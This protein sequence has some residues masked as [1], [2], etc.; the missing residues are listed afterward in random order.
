MRIF[1]QRGNQAQERGSSRQARVLS[2]QPTIATR[3]ASRPPAQAEAPDA[4]SIHT[5]EF[6][7]AHDFSR[8]PAR[9]PT[10]SPLENDIVRE[11]AELGTSGGF[12]ALPQLTEIRRSFGRHDVSH[13]RGHQGSRAAAAARAIGA[14]AFTTG[15]HVVFAVSPDLHTAAHEAAHVVQ[16][17]AGVQLPGNIGEVGDPYERHADA[18]AEKVVRG[19]SAEALLGEMI[20]AGSRALGV[21]RQVVQRAPMA[22]DVELDTTEPDT[23]PRLEDTEEPVP[24]APSAGTISSR[25]R[26]NAPSSPGWEGVD[27]QYILIKSGEP[28]ELPHF[29]KLKIQDNKCKAGKEGWTV[30]EGRYEDHDVCIA[31]GALVAASSVAAGAAAT[32][33]FDIG[34][35]QF[36]YGGTGPIDATTDTT[37]PVPKGTH[38][39][40][41]P[42]FHHD[43]GAKYGDF[44]TTWFRLGHSGDRYLHPGRVSLGCTT[45]KATSEWPKIWKYLISARRDNKN[46]GELTVV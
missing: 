23:P 18:V 12:G 19:H 46:V 13:V 4:G 27:P 5:P 43:L 11:A 14:R 31:G 9:A 16:Q 38:D 42:D 35:G 25:A 24:A 17:R 34:K 44:A 30:L 7:F 32:A 10:E 15:D 40:E 29:L 33:K 3:A 37:N 36:W 20:P 45:I 1:A 21:P 28:V 26:V 8:I 39:I 6:R 41:I 22:T 2:F